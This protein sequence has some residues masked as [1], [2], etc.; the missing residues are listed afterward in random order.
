MTK[1]II[2]FILVL[3]MIISVF[4]I[5][6]VSSAEEASRDT[7]LL[8]DV[9]GSMYGKPLQVM[10]EAAKKFCTSVLGAEGTNRVAIIAFDDDY[11][12]NDFSSDVSE[13]SSYID[14]LT[15]MGMTNV[16]APLEKAHSIL[17]AS[18]ANVKNIVLL[19]DGLPND[20][21]TLSVGKYNSSDSYDYNYANAIYDYAEK[22]LK[23]NYN[24]YTLG[25]FH[26]LSGSDL[27]FARKFLD[28]IQ[29][30]AY[31]DVTDVDKLE[32]TFG[33]VA[34]DIKNDNCPIV[35]IPGIMGSN[36]YFNDHEFDWT[37]KAWAP[38]GL[39][40][41]YTLVML[42]EIMKNW[43][44]YPRPY[45]NQ[46]DNS[47]DREYGAVD[48]YKTLVDKLCEKFGNGDK[49]AKNYREIYFFSYDFRKSNVE[50]ANALEKFIDDK[51][52]KKFDIVAHSM[53][54]L[55]AS[56]YM[57]TE[58]NRNKVR[59]VITCGTPYEGAPKLFNSVLNWDV[60]AH[61]GDEKK[62]KNFFNLIIADPILGLSGLTKDVKASFASTAELVPTENYFNA[63]EK[64]WGRYSY[65][66]GVFS[67]TKYYEDITFE[68]YQDICKIV[69]GNKYDDAYENQSKL[70]VNGYNVLTTLDNSYFVVGV[71]HKTISSIWFNNKKT[72]GK[73]E[74]DDITY[75][76]K[77]DGT[78]PYLSA[79]VM[80]ALDSIPNSAGR[81]L[82]VDANHGETVG[83]D[84]A[85]QWIYEV[86]N[87]DTIS[88]VNDDLKKTNYT[89]IRVACPV[90]VE[91]SKNGEIL[92]S[93]DENLSV[94]S[95]F[96]RLDILG[97]NDDI[98][99]LCVD[100][101]DYDIT[102]TGTD[103]GT[104]NYEIRFFDSNDKLIDS[105][106]FSNVEIEE[107]TIIKTSSE[108]EKDIELVVDKDGDGKTDYVVKN[109]TTT[110]E[111]SG[112]DVARMLYNIIVKLIKFIVKLI[113]NELF[114]A[115][116][117]DQ[118]IINS[119]KI[120]AF[121]DQLGEFVF[122]VATK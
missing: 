4:S 79:T 81:V 108:R 24:V 117:V 114:K 94:T 99:M 25:F 110:G 12:F 61:S 104:M 92:S 26:S 23:P 44:L 40:M 50:S 107:G 60:L 14:G 35:I 19:T 32:F 65:T 95:S 68:E 10:K 118:S 91:I 51:K 111:D 45:E 83:N 47:V 71:N 80:K 120:E 113:Y 78:V 72:L 2:S 105:K 30:R 82:K 96:G 87:D 122:K 66:K 41:P 54:G 8:L 7:V 121:I 56:T 29:N 43:D 88:V 62:D 70:N 84:K 18:T 52:F 106:T 119:D 17:S 16:Y 46:N 11:Y 103:S 74:C 28:D 49:N 13:V 69:F 93:S 116:K 38:S 77:G 6:M 75:E 5:G 67:R 73:I 31:Y 34:E 85:L 20:G 58:E 90:D 98:K 39:S 112:N 109:D 37:T 3:S 53:G 101:D 97:E 76:N 21:E 22:T 55:V 57:K 100:D 89:V 86:L 27:D 36:L 33:E 48:A 59:K 102:L 9:S 42:G 15:D 64:N 63:T 115:D 1:K